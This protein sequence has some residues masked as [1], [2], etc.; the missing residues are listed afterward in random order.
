MQNS[1]TENTLFNE[2][3]TYRGEI[4]SYGNAITFDNKTNWSDN[5][6]NYSCGNTNH[7]DNRENHTYGNSSRSYREENPSNIKKN[8]S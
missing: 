1:L 4:P 5:R 2:N 7:S 8:C 6:E 3:H